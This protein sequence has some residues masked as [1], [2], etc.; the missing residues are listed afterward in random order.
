MT[1]VRGQRSVLRAICSRI[2]AEGRTGTSQN[3]LDQESCIGDRVGRDQAKDP[4]PLWPVPVQIFD[5][6]NK[7]HKI[8]EETPQGIAP[9]FSHLVN[10]VN[11]VETNGTFQR[12]FGTP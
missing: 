2:K 5:R 8:Q 6:I 11:P 12:F 3:K 10:L 4:Q 7:I 9:L 1:E